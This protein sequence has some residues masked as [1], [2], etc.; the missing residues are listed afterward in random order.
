ME[1]LVAS[2]HGLSR[3]DDSGEELEQQLRLL[4]THRELVES[5]RQN[6]DDILDQHITATEHSLAFA[7]LL[8]VKCSV[9]VASY[10]RFFLQVEALANTGKKQQLQIAGRYFVDVC[11]KYADLARERGVPRRGILPLLSAVRLLQDGPGFVTGVH[12][13]FLMLCLLAKC[14]RRALPILEEEVFSV[15]ASNVT[16]KEFMLYGYYGGLVLLGLRRLSEALELFEMAICTPAE[17]LSKIVVDSIQKRLLTSL[18]VHG[19]HSLPRHM[20]REAQRLYITFSR[21]NSLYH[22]FAKVYARL[23]KVELANF[24]ELNAESFKKDGN[25]GLA[26]Q[27]ISSVEERKVLGLTRCFITLSLEDIAKRVG[28]TSPMRAEAVIVRMMEERKI[29]AKV[30]KADGMV[31]FLDDPEKYDSDDMRKLLDLQVRRSVAIAQKLEALKEKVELTP[32]FALFASRQQRASEITSG[33][34]ADVD[35]P[36]F[37]NSV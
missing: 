26:K 35:M 11:S 17:A 8:H 31:T 3:G 2:V 19:K 5:N 12:A 28:I 32:A 37:T 33:W 9:E 16:P 4:V 21:S 13:P 22:D 10:D 29:H 15:N 1:N 25:Y 14:H 30:S 23:D 36:L 7:F 20:P 6:I 27:C 18:L 24:T 34:G